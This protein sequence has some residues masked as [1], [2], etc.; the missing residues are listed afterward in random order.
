MSPSLPRLPPGLAR[1]AGPLAALALALA[2]FGV[3]NR[4]SSSAA[5]TRASARVAPIDPAATTHERIVGLQA[6]LAAGRPVD[7][8]LGAAN[9]QEA[10]ETGD[11][12]AYARA[13]HAFESA[14]RRN[15]RDLDALVG[16]GTLAM[17]R[18]D[19]ANGLAIAER[20][21][22]LAPSALAPFPVL[23]DA[24]VELGR[25][26]EAE[27]AL[28]ELVDRKPGLAAYARVSY[29]RELRGDLPGALEAM[30]YAVSA[31]AA[32]PEG[33]AYVKTL[34]GTLQFNRGRLDRAASAYAAAG[35]AVPGFPAAEAGL[36]RVDAAHGRLAAAITRLRDVVG[37]LPLPE[38][39]VA[40]GETE[41]AAGR[42][43]A[44]RDD[45]DLVR[46]ER[47]LLAAAGV[48]TDVELALFEA[49]H[50]DRRAGVA[51]G[52]RSWTAAPSVRSA[53]AL[54][55]ALTRAGRPE[56]GAAW[57]RRALRRGWREPLA[58]YHAGMSAAAAGRRED[59]RRVLGRL[60]RQ[61]PR[62]SAL[63]APRARRALE[64]AR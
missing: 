63:L 32:T 48:N 7:A 19:F 47:R 10:R 22:R 9:L 33:L 23:V 24:L 35:R 31:G 27:R 17:A 45:L 14:L 25:Y 4:G 21:R 8:A 37:R 18:H 29:L 13:Q 43:R 53:D 44:A 2:V 28:Q 55:W 38:Y 52:R 34:E 54:G 57:G 30:G 39:V 3:V 49:D 41:L 42:T 36:A 51:L 26:P 58:L 61:A 46:V 56:E 62:F 1:I 40:L 60:L 15:P 5:P 64:A 16:Q 12:G 50:G 11:A 20:A 6:Q 59:A